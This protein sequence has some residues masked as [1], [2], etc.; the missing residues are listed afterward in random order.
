[1]PISPALEQRLSS[2][3]EGER[4]RALREL[5]AT[6]SAAEAR[7]WL[8]KA[9]GDSSRLVRFLARELLAEA[10][11][12]SVAAPGHHPPPPTP[13]PTGP[14]GAGWLLFSF[15]G[16]I[17]RFTFWTANIVLA[18]VTSAASAILVLG[19]GDSVVGGLLAVLLSLP[20][21]WANLAL[22]AK[23]WHDRDKSGW[24]ILIS[25][26]PIVGGLWAFVE[27][28]LLPG[29]PGPNQYGESPY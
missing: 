19:F 26:V 2:P 25:L 14:R 8:L 5:A 20:A 16:R 9:S 1:M 23:R 21:A 7:P 24:W 4:H 18:V 28:C 10:G 11:D 15:E 29:T 22:Q 13:G 3:S 27:T 17:G 12:R 6:C